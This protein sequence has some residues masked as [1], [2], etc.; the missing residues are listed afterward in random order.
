MYNI[1]LVESYDYLAE[2]FRAALSNRELYNL[3]VVESGYTAL[4]AVD[5]K[6]FDLIIIEN[7]LPYLSGVKT[8]R[9]LRKKLSYESTPFI[10]VVPSTNREMVE[11][12]FGSGVADFLTIPL[13]TLAIQKTVE[14]VLTK[15]KGPVNNLKNYEQMMK[16]MLVK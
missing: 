2:N 1:L 6:H 7:D 10:A 3:V 5:L 15:W 8:A 9:N 16:K 4:E 13:H 14:N 11:D 12:Y